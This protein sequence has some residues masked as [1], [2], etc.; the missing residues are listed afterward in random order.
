MVHRE[1]VTSQVN[2]LDIIAGEPAYLLIAQR[3]VRQDGKQR[4]ITQKIRVLD[5]AVFSRLC[6]AVNKG[7]EIEVTIVTE[8]SKQG[9]TSHLSDFRAPLHA[10][11]SN[12]SPTIAA[13]AS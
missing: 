1:E 11:E 5:A 12:H 6:T 3:A 4:T 13:K 2:V 10:A 8:W 9:Y 7:D